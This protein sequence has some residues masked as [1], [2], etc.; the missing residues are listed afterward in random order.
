MIRSHCFNVPLLSFSNFCFRS[1]AMAVLEVQWPPSL[2][3]CGVVTTSLCKTD[4]ASC[5]G[6]YRNL[7][8]TS[9]FCAHRQANMD[10][11]KLLNSK[12]RKVGATERPAAAVKAR[13]GGR[14]KVSKPC[15]KVKAQRVKA[16]RKRAADALQQVAPKDEDGVR[17][18]L[19]LVLIVDLSFF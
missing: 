5:H 16:C 7:I 12:P 11:A 19:S 18:I 15:R 9:A 17:V 6:P 14:L 1:R 3:Q 8:N 4:I 13:A 2:Q 10:L